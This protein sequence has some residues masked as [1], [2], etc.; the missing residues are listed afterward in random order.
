MGLLPLDDIENVTPN[1]AYFKWVDKII[2]LAET[3]GLY[4]ALLPTWGD[5]VSKQ[6]G[7]GPEIFTPAY[8]RA[9][10]T[11]LGKRYK[12]FNNIIWINGGD[13]WGGDGNYPT[14]DALGKGL[15]STDKNHLV[16]FHP[17]T[18]YSS[19]QWYHNT[20]W[21]DFNMIHTGQ[22]ENS[23]DIYDRLTG[24]DYNREE[25]R[26]VLTGNPCYENHAVC[27]QPDS[28]GYF[29]DADIRR[30]MY[31]SLFSG[32]CGHTYGCT[33]VWNTT[34]PD[35]T[36]AG[37]QQVGHARR[38]WERFSWDERIP[39]QELLTSSNQAKALK[40]PNYGLI[41]LPYGGETVID[42]NRFASTQSFQFKWMNPRTGEISGIDIQTP[43]K[44]VKVNPPSSGNGNDW[45][46]IITTKQ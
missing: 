44:Q 33:D 10:G 1:E 37:I 43:D 32:A 39:A 23:F 17:P 24:K 12:N 40:G 4:M 6:S 22:C 14:W 5:K 7:R 13:R 29:D 28:L 26:P 30:A 8:A 21:L 2:R 38:L 42:L 19:S 35:K 20:S 36:P 41:Y 46:L 25:V 45:I 34:N 18:G 15:K 3:K 11:W 16:T 9:Y 27:N 31:W